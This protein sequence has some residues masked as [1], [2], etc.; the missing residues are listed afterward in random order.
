MTQVATLLFVVLLVMQFSMMKWEMMALQRHGRPL[1]L[2]LIPI[3]S[4]LVIGYDAIA[5][6]VRRRG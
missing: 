1:W 5:G 6:R 4:L 2:A 3:V